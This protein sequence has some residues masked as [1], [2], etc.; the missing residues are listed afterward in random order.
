MEEE[1]IR[2]I[3]QHGWRLV[4][5]SKQGWPLFAGADKE[6]YIYYKAHYLTKKEYWAVIKKEPKPAKPI[7]YGL[8]KIPA[9]IVLKYVNQ[10]LGAWKSY[11]QELEHDIKELKKEREQAYQ[12]GKKYIQEIREKETYKKLQ[13]QIGLLQAA[14]HRYSKDRDGFIMKIAALELENK[15]LRE[16]SERIIQ[17]HQEALS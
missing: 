6:T 16:E 17:E 13:E 14:Q 2:V 4:G 1:N 10:E 15:K 7:D 3:A 5:F 12:K 11:S 8:E 9:E